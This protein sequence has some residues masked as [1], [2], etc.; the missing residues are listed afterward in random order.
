[1][2]LPLELIEAIKLQAAHQG[3]SITAY[4]AALVRADL[5]QPALPDLRQLADQV[6]QL[7]QLQQRVEQLERSVQGN[8]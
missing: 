3:V 2:V 6:Q 8:P 4:I 7:Q 1:M 5:G